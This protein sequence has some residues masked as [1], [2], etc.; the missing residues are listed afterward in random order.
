MTLFSID[1]QKCN[2]DGICADECPLKLISHAVKNSIPVLVPGAE[3]LCIQCGHC[4]AVCPTSALSHRNLTP[5]Q[6]LPVRKD[7]TLDVDQ[8]EHF[9]RQRRSIRTYRKKT[10]EREILARLI[11][12]ASHAP[13]GHNTQPVKWHVIHDRDEL[14]RQ[15]G[16]VA[17]WMRYMIRDQ[18]EMAKRLHMEMIVAAWDL[19]IDVICRDA[20]HLVA[21]CGMKSDP[22][23]QN[24]SLIAMTYLDL[25]VPVFGLGSCWAGFF[26][27]AA[28]SWPPLRSAMG[29]PEGD[30]VHAAMM[31]GYPKH[32][33][34]R[35]PPRN[36]PKISWK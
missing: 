13:S 25:A 36:A 2:R 3:R 15:T 24:A 11:S 27:V 30:A 32:K 5:D 34:H 22:T 4:V 29:L 7:W 17:D 10:V 1:P 26:T 19:G 12:I 21:A 18:P 14:H 9:L 6:C 20:P 33:Y 16:M 23:A 31:V 8:A 35:M 28:T